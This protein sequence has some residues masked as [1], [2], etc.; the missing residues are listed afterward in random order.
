[1]GHLLAEACRVGREEALVA[2][3]ETYRVAKLAGE[4]LR[5]TP[6]PEL[7]ARLGLGS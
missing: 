7:K 6:V 2:M 1:M 4:Q 3:R 5:D